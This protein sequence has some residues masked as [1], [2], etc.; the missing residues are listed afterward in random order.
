MKTG[1][2]R[3]SLWSWKSWRKMFQEW[4]S[5]RLDICWGVLFLM[6]LHWYVGNKCPVVFLMTLCRQVGLCL[7][8]RLSH[9]YGESRSTATLVCRV[10]WDFSL[11]N[12][13]MLLAAVKEKY[14][15]IFRQILF[16]FC[17]L[18]VTNGDLWLHRN[19]IRM[20]M[21]QRMLVFITCPKEWT[22]SVFQSQ[23]TAL[24]C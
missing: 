17:C 12:G 3:I 20:E 2:G 22:D 11:K 21:D 24:T 13:L 5:G 23:V 18:V 19:F 6:Q 4:N 15:W 8:L 14:E 10:L 9:G 1:A 7:E 16:S